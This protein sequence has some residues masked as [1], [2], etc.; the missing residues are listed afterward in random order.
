MTQMW[1]CKWGRVSVKSGAVTQVGMLICLT[2]C[3]CGK[4]T[5]LF[6]VT[7]D[8]FISGDDPNHL[9]TPAGLCVDGDGRILIVDN[10]MNQVSIFDSSG[11]FTAAFGERGEGPGMLSNL[12]FNFCVD[13]SGYSYLIDDRSTIDVF[14]RNGEYLRGIEHPELV[15]FDVAV[16]GSFI[17]LSC[18]SPLAGNSDGV[19]V[20][21]SEDG[22][23]VRRFGNVPSDLSGLPPWL[24][25]FHQTC[26]IDVDADGNIY[27]TS[28]LDYSLYKYSLDGTLVFCSEPPS[29][30]DP[31]VTENM[32]VTPSV[33]DL[34]VD[35]GMV[36]VLWGASEGN[37]GAR[38]D[39]FS[40]ETGDYMGCFYTG[41]PMEDRPPF[42]CIRNGRDLYT[43]EMASAIVYRLEL[44]RP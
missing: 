15:I 13:D 2:C 26:P 28:I 22:R 16:A 3:G 29:H 21:M 8:M 18:P 19:L 42:I 31:V 6:Q 4:P 39:V 34:C 12:F 44:S 36:F 5:E 27:Y 24:S 32:I 17:V 23:I 20:V 9:F 1:I 11:A 14:D 37:K 10:I 35:D 30:L 40:C 38:V 43:A 7:P 41:I 33:W 25:I